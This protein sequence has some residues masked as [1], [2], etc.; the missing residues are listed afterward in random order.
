[1]DSFY[2][3]RRRA[4]GLASRCKDCELYWERA[5]PDS[6]RERMKRWR[7]NKNGKDITPRV[8]GYVKRLQAFA[9]DGEYDGP[10]ADEAA[11]RLL[12]FERGEAYKR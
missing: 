11:E 8:T 6:H 1:M 10:P 7:E 9:N 4:D 2:G 12:R 5:N 3:N